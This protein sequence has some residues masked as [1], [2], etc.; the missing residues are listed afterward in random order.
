MSFFR[1]LPILLVLALVSGCRDQSSSIGID[2]PYA[3]ASRTANGAAFLHIVNSGGADRLIAADSDAALSVELHE[4]TMEDSTMQMRRVDGFDIPA[5]GSLTLEPRGK[6][7]M[8]MG[9][10]KPLVEGE[11]FDLTLTFEK[12]GAMTFPVLIGAA[13]QKPDMAAHDHVHDHDHG[14]HHHH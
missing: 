1:F 6:H 9:L 3:F 14:D 8:L 10:E 5:K 11:T 7:I 2:E 4:T 12:A 13:G